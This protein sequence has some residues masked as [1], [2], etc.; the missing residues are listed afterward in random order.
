MKKP[1]MGI[2][3]PTIEKRTGAMKRFDLPLAFVEW[4][5]LA[6][7]RAVWCQRVTE[8]PFAIGKPFVRIPRGDSRAT[9]EEKLRA[10]V[11]RAAEAAER[12]AEV[13]TNFTAHQPQNYS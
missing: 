13:L 5:A 3:S 7:Y 8:P 10:K 11:Q 1:R 6:Q 4:A 9:P 2:S 12:Q